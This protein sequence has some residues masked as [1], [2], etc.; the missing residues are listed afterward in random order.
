MAV[1][2]VPSRNRG[3]LVRTAARNQGSIISGLLLL[4]L[5]VIYQAQAGKIL[6]PIQVRIL[7]NGALALVWAALGLTFVVV[8]GGFDLSVG[9]LM[10]LANVLAAT[11]L[12]GTAT[13][14]L[15]IIGILALGGLAGLVNGVLIAVVRIQS[16]IV[17]LA[18]MFIWSGVA[19]LI[20][21]QPGGVIPGY[22]S[23]LTGGT[24]GPVPIALV[25]LVVI[26][27]AIALFRQTSGW[28]VLFSVGGDE[29]A[30]RRSGVRV[31]RGKLLA[32]TAA[33]VC[34]ALAG[35]FLSAQ[36]TGGDANIGTPFLL[37][38]FAAVILGGTPLGGGRGTFV[39][40]IFGALVVATLGSV[41]LSLGVT[42]YWTDVVQGAV[43]I[44][45]VV[46]PTVASRIAGRQASMGGR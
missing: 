36:S 12:A 33:G 42:S 19:L 14:P 25:W 41:L 23:D 30:A 39:G 10:S 34:Y 17:T 31:T 6:S 37:T 1:A 28:S 27:A 38:A 15:V 22:V 40:A 16:I 18:A 5:L 2:A 43:L 32:Y 8:A 13:D 24:L 46:L 35:L 29:V 11:L 3:G 20:M 21:P 26:L 9:S 7:L 45:A 4:A 44:F